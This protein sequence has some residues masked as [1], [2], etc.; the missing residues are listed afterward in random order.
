MTLSALPRDAGSGGFPMASSADGWRGRIGSSFSPRDAGL[1]ARCVLDRLE[2]SSTGRVVVSHDSRQGGDAAA[3]AI[4][5]EIRARRPATEIQFLPHLPTPVASALLASGRADLAFLVT[6]SHNPASWNGVKVKVPPG[7]PLSGADEAW[8]DAAY[9]ASRAEDPPGA[10]ALATELP[11]DTQSAV[12]EHARSLAE[13][14]GFVDQRGRRVVVDGLHGIAGAPMARFLRRLGCETIVLGAEP[15]PD[16]AGLRPD[17]TSAGA[18]ARCIA[19]VRSAEAEFGIV[20]DG[21]GDRMIVVDRTGTPIQSQALMSVLVEFAP[22]AIQPRLSGDVLVTTTCGQMMRALARK[23]GAVIEETPVGFKYIGRLL[24]ERRDSVGVGSVGDF[25]FQAF[26]TDRDPMAAAL[27]LLSILDGSGAPLDAL[28][29][30]LRSRLGLTN[31]EW[32]E[33][34]LPARDGKGTELQDLLREAADSLGWEGDIETTVDGLRLHG[35]DRAWLLARAS[36]TEGGCRLYGEV[37]GA[38]RAR[39]LD[40]GAS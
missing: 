8:V 30:D 5:A 23:R 36:T 2:A 1:I 34:H 17:P 6:A 35:P 12:D 40:A 3:S 27:L 15:L 18:C 38:D 21:D 31:I 24:R 14:I 33:M 7:S 9:Q 22:P 28:V 13:R 11:A 39:L 29:A 19:A 26:T 16:F 32:V 25:G 20:L 37:A 4:I 10:T